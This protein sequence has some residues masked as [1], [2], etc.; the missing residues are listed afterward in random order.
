[1]EEIEKERGGD[2][3]RAVDRAL[4]IL[5]AFGAGD[6]ELTVAELLK[7]VDLSRPTLYRLLYTLQ[8]NGF[9][10][11]NGEPQR[12]RLGPAVGRLA[13]AWTSSFDLAEI[14]QPILRELWEE[15]GETVAL[16]IPHGA[17]RQ[18][19][20]ELPSTQP[21]SFKRGVGYSEKIA[22]GASGRAL[23]AWMNPSEEQLRKYCEGLDIDPFALAAQLESVRQS[24]YAESQNELIV[25]AVAIAVPFFDRKEHA[26]GS[27]AIF[28]PTVRLDHA[29]VEE[30]ANTLREHAARLSALLGSS[31]NR[32]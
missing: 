19:I 24:G 28:G 18:C 1:M 12:F 7:R 29:R 30:L 15:T 26:V 3:V 13:W 11:A 10:T 25:G 20:A 4:D 6:R 5:S 23:L 22:R 2:G 9:L 27:V 16:F 32:L 17:T 14:A 31:E 8:Q 21:L